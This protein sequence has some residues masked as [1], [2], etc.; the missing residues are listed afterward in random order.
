MRHSPLALPVGL[1][2]ALAIFLAGCAEKPKTQVVKED[3]TEVT[4]DKPEQPAGAETE[5]TPP[6]LGG[7]EN[8]AI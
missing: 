1:S 2:L 8:L 4:T 7:D 3:A 6:T 5:P